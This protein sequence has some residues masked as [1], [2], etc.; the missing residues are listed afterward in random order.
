M[1]SLNQALAHVH[2]LGYDLILRIIA[3]LIRLFGG[4]CEQ[5][6]NGFVLQPLFFVAHNCL[7]LASAADDLP[8]GR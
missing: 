4:L 1:S 3:R 5:R 6:L 8:S 2:D 7:P